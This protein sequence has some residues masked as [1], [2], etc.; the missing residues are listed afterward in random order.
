MA[1]ND[2]EP[3][4]PFEKDVCIE[5]I[6]EIGKYFINGSDIITNHILSDN[7]SNVQKM[8]LW[9]DIKHKWHNLHYM[10][11]LPLLGKLIVFYD[12]YYQ[13]KVIKELKDVDISKQTISLKDLQLHILFASFNCQI[14]YMYKMLYKDTHKTMKN[15][16][17]THQNEIT[18]L[19]SLRDKK[20]QYDTDHM[21]GLPRIIHINF[22]TEVNLQ[23]LCIEKDL[24][25]KTLHCIT[26]HY[27]DHCI[28]LHSLKL[29]IYVIL[30]ILDTLD[31]DS[32]YFRNQFKQDSVIMFQGFNT[33]HRIYKNVYI[34]DCLSPLQKIRIIEKVQYFKDKQIGKN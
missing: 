5:L 30:W 4:E 32:E 23:N 1:N 24:L 20:N 22:D 14:E 2:W 31:Y 13:N 28:A 21:L 33:N 25:V 3:Q 18:R 10:V 27:L 29:P 16:L 9:H 15:L 6:K 26:N 8:L 19:R 11:E 17:I 7:K 12:Y 34:F